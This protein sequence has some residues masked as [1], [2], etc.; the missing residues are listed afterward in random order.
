MFLG[1]QPL[2]SHSA[3]NTDIAEVTPLCQEPQ[4]LVWFDQ[5]TDMEFGVSVFG[6]TQSLS[7]TKHLLIK[8]G[9]ER[10]EYHMRV[11]APLAS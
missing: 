11:Q 8:E 1:P 7:P 6:I 10:E 4:V 2:G 9:R 3:N 5:R